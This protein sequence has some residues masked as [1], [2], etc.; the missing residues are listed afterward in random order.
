VKYEK[1]KPAVQ[2]DFGPS[3]ARPEWYAIAYRAW[4]R[5]RAKRAD[6]KLWAQYI[7]EMSDTSELAAGVLLGADEVLRDERGWVFRFPRK[8]IRYVVGAGGRY[9]EIR[10]AF[11]HAVGVPLVVEALDVGEL[12]EDGLR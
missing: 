7:A 12:S 2:I 6:A 4:R 8:S 11:F 3:S 10:A 1:K 5:R 9:D